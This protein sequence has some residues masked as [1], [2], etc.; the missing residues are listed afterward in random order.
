MSKKTLL[1]IVIFSPIFAIKSIKLVSTGKLFFMCALLTFSK[2]DLFS[3]IIVDTSLQKEINV[4]FFATK[5]VSLLISTKDTSPSFSCKRHKP[6]AAVLL[7]LLVAFAIPFFLKNSIAFSM[8]P[9]TSS[10][11]SLQSLNPTPVISLSFFTLSSRSLL[12]IK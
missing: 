1:L 6:S 9:L 10:I 2:S 12:D 5:S 3:K 4:S 8:S 7:I 11:A